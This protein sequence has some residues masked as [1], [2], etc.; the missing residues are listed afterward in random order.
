MKQRPSPEFANGLLGA[1]WDRCARAPPPD[2]RLGFAPRTLVC[3][4]LA[5]IL[6]A[7]SPIQAQVYQWTDA[8]GRVHYS[9]CVE[10]GCIGLA[11]PTVPALT[12]RQVGEAGARARQPGQWLQELEQDRIDTQ[13]GPALLAAIERGDT[14]A[15]LAY[16][17]QGVSPDYADRLGRTAL[18]YA[19]ING[20]VRVVARSLIDR[21]ADVNRASLDG[22]T[23]LMAAAIFG[24]PEGVGALL[25]KGAKAD[26]RDRAGRTALDWALRRGESAPPDRRVFPTV[27]ERTADGDFTYCTRAEYA[28]VVALLLAAA[29]R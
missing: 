3:A 22:S 2:R 20:L 11:L 7:A 16:L 9:D 13:L 15:F 14:P 8:Q 29:Q 25:D 28:Q 24:D 1:R 6:F 19:E 26:A 5:S 4:W 10:R 12:P 17:H 18:M 21:G 23:A 27:P